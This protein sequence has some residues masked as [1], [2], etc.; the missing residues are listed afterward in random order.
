MTSTAKVERM[1]GVDG[2]YSL[3]GECQFRTRKNK[4]QLGRK[5]TVVLR[6]FPCL[7]HLL[8]KCAEDFLYFLLFRSRELREVVIQ[9]HGDH[10][11]HKKRLPGG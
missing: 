8:G 11:L 5:V 9:A 7:F 3:H 2:F 6:N 10:R 1:S 4:L